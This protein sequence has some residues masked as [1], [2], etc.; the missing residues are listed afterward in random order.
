MNHHRRRDAWP[1]KNGTRGVAVRGGRGVRAARGEGVT[2]YYVAVSRTGP[3]QSI[4]SVEAFGQPV[5]A[6]TGLAASALGLRATIPWTPSPG[7]TTYDLYWDTA[8]GVTPAT[9]N[10]IADATP[11]RLHGQ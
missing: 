3:R 2:Y 10:R 9:G 6:P 4:E 1:G 7:A 8:P 11:P 5:G